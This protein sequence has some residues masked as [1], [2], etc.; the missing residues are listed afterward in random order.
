MQDF[1]ELPNNPTIYSSLCEVSKGLYL[2]DI[3]PVEANGSILTC[4][5][6]YRKNIITCKDHYCNEFINEV[7]GL[8][9][10]VKLSN[11]KLALPSYIPIVDVRTANLKNIPKNI[12]HIG[13]TVTDILSKVVDFKAGSYQETNNFSLKSNILSLNS[14]KDRENILFLTGCDT[15]IEWLWYNRVEFDLFNGISKMGFSGVSAFNFSVIGGECAFSQALNIKRSL[16][17][18]HVLNQNGINAIPHVYAL[19]Y[20]QANRWVEWFKL[21]PDTNIF[22]VN[23]QLQKSIR[24]IGQIIFMVKY[25]LEKLPNIH[26]ILQGFRIDM[27]HHFG[28]YLPRIHISDKLAVKYAQSKVMFEINVN[29]NLL[30]NKPSTIYDFE[31]LAEENIKIRNNY[32]DQLKNKILASTYKVAV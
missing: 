2:P 8:K 13:L 3:N 21:N 5:N 6:P 4:E 22:S 11:N 28:I 9:L 12:T 19:N 26:V 23:C 24:D 16:F 15:L 29:K 14:F 30:E 25:L 10:N 7:G 17:S 1:L 18:S 20:F 32:I 27:L 31:K